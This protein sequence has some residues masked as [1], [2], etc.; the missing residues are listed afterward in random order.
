M[1]KN[2]L[3]L[4]VSNEQPKKNLFNIFWEWLNEPHKVPF[5]LTYADKR[6]QVIKYLTLKYADYQMV[7]G[8]IGLFPLSEAINDVERLE[9]NN[10][11][12]R[13]YNQNKRRITG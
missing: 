7:T 9:Q 4:V 8:D 13:Y 1:K 11:L 2:H 5:V 12:E 3:R 10:Q 6:E